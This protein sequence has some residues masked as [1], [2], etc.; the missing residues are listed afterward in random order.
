GGTD[1]KPLTCDVPPVPPVPPSKSS[2]SREDTATVN[3]RE[4]HDV[5]ERRGRGVLDVDGLHLA[6]V[7]LPEPVDLPENLAEAYG[8]AERYG[9]SQL[10]IHPRAARGLEL[11]DERE[12]G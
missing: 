8:M 4:V 6:D 5:T 1:S 3:A 7:D 11:P 10:W 2:G 9:L 12:D